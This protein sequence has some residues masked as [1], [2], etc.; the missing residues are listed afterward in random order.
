MDQL[1]REVKHIAIVIDHPDGSVTT[2]RAER[3][4]RPSL[5]IVTPLDRHPVEGPLELVTP[6]AVSVPEL[7]RVKVGFSA[8]PRHPLRAE[9]GAVPGPGLL[10]TLLAF[11]KATG[12]TY[13]QAREYAT[14]LD[15]AAF[16]PLVPR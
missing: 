13:E 14:R 5:E 2:F 8:D 9:Y 15:S 10:E 11:V 1:P 6:Y 4:V 7:S 16:P 3:P 12:W